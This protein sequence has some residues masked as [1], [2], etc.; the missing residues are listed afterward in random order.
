MG[1]I[2]SRI[3]E[4]LNRHD[5]PDAPWKRVLAALAVAGCFITAAYQ[6]YLIVF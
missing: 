6:I 3:C 2:Y 4:L 1:G 5:V